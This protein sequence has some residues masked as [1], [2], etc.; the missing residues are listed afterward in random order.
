MQEI[1]LVEDHPIVANSVMHLL[2]L[3]LPSYTF[4]SVCSGHDGLAYLNNHHPELI[5]LDINLPDMN[6]IEFCKTALSRFPKLNI[7][8]FTSIE[9]RHVVEQMLEAGAHGFILK[10]SD[11]EEINEAI[12]KVLNGK[13][14][15]GKQV[16]ELLKGKPG[17]DSNMPVLTRREIEVL[18]LIA[19]GLTNQQIADKLFISSWTVDSHRKNLLIKFE[20]KNTASLIKLAALNGLLDY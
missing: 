8:A 5:I 17:S 11:V 6:G 4:S 15:I 7:L 18:K 13:K 20:A 14:Y 2:Q 1:L 19:E 16:N 9:H 12:V 3:M 10:N